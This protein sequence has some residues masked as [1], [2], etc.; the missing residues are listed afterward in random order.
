MKT[1][2]VHL[3]I[4]TTLGYVFC[5][6]LRT[7]LR[8]GVIK[9]KKISVHMKHFTRWKQLLEVYKFVSPLGYA[10]HFELGIWPGL[11]PATKK[12]WFW[13]RICTGSSQIHLVVGPTAIFKTI[14]VFW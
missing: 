6:L 4:C 7:L 8:P 14:R 10:K 1:V 3:I 2:Q 12:L 9:Q 13:F 11:L 5:C